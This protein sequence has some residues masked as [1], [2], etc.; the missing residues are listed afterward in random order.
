M[1]SWGVDGH[2]ILR[3]GMCANELSGFWEWNGP[4][5]KP[6]PEGRRTTIG[7]GV[8]PRKNCFAATVTR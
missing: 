5:E 4:P 7:T 3:P 2:T 1:A 8:R 6:P